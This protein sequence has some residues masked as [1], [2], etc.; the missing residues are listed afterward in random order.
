M[1]SPTELKDLRKKVHVAPRCAMMY[2]H[3]CCIS[4]HNFCQN[5]K[6]ALR[7]DFHAVTR[8]KRRRI[9]GGKYFQCAGCPQNGPPVVWCLVI[10][11]PFLTC[12]NEGRSVL[13]NEFQGF[14]A[15]T[16]IIVKTMI[17]QG[18]AQCAI[19]SGTFFCAP[20]QKNQ[21]S[22]PYQMN[23]LV[24]FA[25]LIFFVQVRKNVHFCAKSALLREKSHFS[26]KRCIFAQKV[27]GAS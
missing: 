7:N 13:S 4:G 11:S 9:H 10:F 12:G 15:A 25:F 24:R 5:V 19:S 27:T 20:A 8:T 18:F 6:I 2:I 26:A 3:I 1:L 17:F 22:K 23:H 14:L 16:N 21:K